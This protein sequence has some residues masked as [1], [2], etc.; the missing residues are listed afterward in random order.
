MYESKKK[1]FY[2]TGRRKSSVARV[3]VYE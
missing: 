3:R 1:Y 2:G